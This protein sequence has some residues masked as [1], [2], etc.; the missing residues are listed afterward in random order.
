MLLFGEAAL[1]SFIFADAGHALIAKR[2]AAVYER[3]A[4]P[5]LGD[6]QLDS[7]LIGDSQMHTA[8]LEHPGFFKLALT[9][10]TTP[11]L[12]ILVREYFRFRTPKKVIIEAG[13]QFFAQAQLDNGMRRHEFYFAQN[14]WI[15]HAT[16]I[17]SY[18]A[19]P[20]IG[21]HIGEALNVLLAPYRPRWIEP[22]AA[23]GQSREAVPAPAHWGLYSADERRTAVSRRI[24]V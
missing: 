10:E 12:E 17:R 13:P 3:R 8:F 6:S 7:V 1:R 14:N 19:E 15:Q 11:M 16:G 9:A 2:V 4:W 5:V 20:D 22:V 21:S 24:A 23:A 18:L